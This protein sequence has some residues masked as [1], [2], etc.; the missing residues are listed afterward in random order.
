VVVLVLRGHTGAR[1]WSGRG[2]E[3]SQMRLKRGHVGMSAALR[4]KK[5][6]RKQEWCRPVPRAGANCE[7]AAARCGVAAVVARG[8]LLCWHAG[9]LVAAGI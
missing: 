4:R 5:S 2:R 1:R 3:R 9:N 6:R 8:L 7:A